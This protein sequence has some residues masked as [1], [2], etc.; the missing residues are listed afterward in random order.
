LTLYHISEEQGI[1]VFSPRP[2]ENETCGVKG[3]AVWA[4]DEEHLPNYLLPR[5]C[6]RVTYFVGETT[7]EADAQRFFGGTHAKRIIAVESGWFTRIAQQ[8]LYRYE[9]DSS[10]FECVD[11]TAG[12]YVSRVAVTPTRETKIEDPVSALLEVGAELRVTPQ[13]WRLREQVVHSTLGYSIIRMRNAQ[14]PPEG[15]E[16]YHPLPG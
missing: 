13:L 7:T 1:R 5:D 2:L 14:V 3:S 9:F 6:P 10:R 11:T 16:R 8:R 15:T 12:Y 4:I